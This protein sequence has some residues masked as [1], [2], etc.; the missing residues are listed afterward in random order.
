ML[1]LCIQV[2]AFCPHCYAVNK[3]P[4]K[5]GSTMVCLSNSSLPNTSHLC[6]AYHHPNAVN[7]KSTFF[8]VMMIFMTMMIVQLAMITLGTACIGMPIPRRLTSP[9]GCRF[10]AVNRHGDR[11]D[12]QSQHDKVAPPC[13]PKRALPPGNRKK[14]CFVENRG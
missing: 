6:F 5:L 4:N 7:N 12:W 3:V 14:S 9:R 2:Y 8:E 11:K 1:Q 13:P 10:P